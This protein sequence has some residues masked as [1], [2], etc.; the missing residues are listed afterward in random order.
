[1][2]PQLPIDILPEILRH[3]VGELDEQEILHNLL[4]VNRT[5]CQHSLPLLWTNPFLLCQQPENRAK[6]VETL[7]GCLSDQDKAYF[8]QRNP[9]LPTYA[10]PSIDYSTYITVLEEK[11]VIEAVNNWF[12]KILK[13]KKEKAALAG[14]TI[15]NTSKKENDRKYEATVLSA[16]LYKMF[17]ERSN[18]IKWFNLD[19]DAIN[20]KWYDGTITHQDYM[21]DKILQAVANYQ[22][23]LQRLAVSFNSGSSNVD[24]PGLSKLVVECIKVQGRFLRDFVI[25][26]AGGDEF[27]EM[28]YAL[29]PRANSLKRVGYTQC[30]FSKFPWAVGIEIL[31]Q[32]DE[33]YFIA[34]TNLRDSQLKQLEGRMEKPFPE[35]YY[36]VLKGLE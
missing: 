3:F 27:A 15:N 36:Y 21:A 32:I 12:E 22:Q 28:H 34:C 13:E 14:V 19:C 8:A 7:L 23:S 29:K 31:S 24:T 25:E 33:L 30:D 10:R 4:F 17:I 16:M 2:P 35:F 18:N 20:A 6:L 11:N 1:M 5:W 26:N 9:D